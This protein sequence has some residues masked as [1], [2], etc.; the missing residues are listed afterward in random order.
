MS[1]SRCQP[2]MTAPRSAR[3]ADCRFALTK[4]DTLQAALS[5]LL[6]LA[7]NPEASRLSPLPSPIRDAAALER[8]ASEKARRAMEEE[9][10]RQAAM[11]SELAATR[12]LIEQHAAVGCPPPL[13]TPGPGPSCRL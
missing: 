7:D 3:H 2:Q 9:V 12:R 4:A 6:D 1:G 5:I 8:Q 10:A 11:Q 13:R